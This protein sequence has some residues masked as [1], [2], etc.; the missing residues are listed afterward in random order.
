MC[1]YRSCKFIVKKI[2]FFTK[3]ISKYLSNQVIFIVYITQ[4]SP[5]LRVYNSFMVLNFLKWEIDISEDKIINI[6]SK[7]PKRKCQCC[8][9]DYLPILIDKNNKEALVSYSTEYTDSPTINRGHFPPVPLCKGCLQYKCKEFNIDFDIDKINMELIQAMRKLKENCEFTTKKSSEDILLTSIQD[10][11]FNG[12]F[13]Q[14]QELKWIPRKEM[15]PGNIFLEKQFNEF[16]FCRYQFV[17]SEWKQNFRCCQWLG[18]NS[19]LQGRFNGPDFIL[20]CDNV[21]LGLEVEIMDIDSCFVKEE[22]NTTEYVNGIFKNKKIK[23]GTFDNYLNRCIKI[24]DKKYSKKNK[25]LPTSK[26]CL[27]IPTTAMTPICFYPLIE[28]LLNYS[29]KYVDMEIKLI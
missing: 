27:L 2:H 29:K 14:N 24:A 22:K 7:L 1:F 13:M 12:N 18:S 19:S 17:P 25:Y 11:T 3:I 4:C 5:D 8:G 26:L 9:Q 20:V 16:S 23:I 21:T 10:I 15:P 28:M 6:F